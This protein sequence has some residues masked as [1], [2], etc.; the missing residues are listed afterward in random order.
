MGIV[1]ASA[2]PPPPPPSLSSELPPSLVK[3]DFPKASNGVDRLENPG[4]IEDLHKKCKGTV[5]NLCH[6]FPFLLLCLFGLH[7]SAEVRI[8]FFLDFIT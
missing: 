6:L 3:K 5:C 7:P 8:F 2:A 1:H 4:T